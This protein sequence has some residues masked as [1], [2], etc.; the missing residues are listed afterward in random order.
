MRIVSKARHRRLILGTAVFLLSAGAACAE[1]DLITLRANGSAEGVGVSA[2]NAGIAAAQREALD[3]L[4]QS[5]APGGT[6][7]VFEPI[8]RN[9]SKY[10][11]SYDV[12]RCDVEGKRTH[13]EIDAHFLERPLR[14]DVAATMLPRLAS[15]PRIQLLIGEQIGGDKIIAV[16]DQG[17]AETA[18]RAGLK[19]L[20]MESLGSDSLG[21]LYTQAQLIGI[22]NGDVESGGKFARAGLADVVVVGTAVNSSEETSRGS[23]LMKTR[24]V[25][26][27]RVFRGVDGKMVDSLSATAVVNGADT[28]ASG[29]QAVQDACDKLSGEMVVSAVLT[30]LS[31]RPPD[32][33]ILVLD[34]P[35][36]HE[37]LQ[38]VM[39]TIEGM[40]GVSGMEELAYSDALARV[41]FK[42]DGRMALLV[43]ALTS[44]PFEGKD[45]RVR[46]VVA[47]EMET[48]F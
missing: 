5:M 35:G 14:Q 30:V 4:V 46:K 10:V 6:K 44:Q 25:V 20:G 27:L 42:F 19:K 45:L 1:E 24:T 38:A 32:A 3:S 22:V 48:E 40:Q 34:K 21:K 8:L 28:T 9:A 12:L 33:V 41:R 23:N 18:L 11:R 26:T 13:V 37:R 17:L 2:R 15:P 7:D 43:Q 47:R 31:A 16:P 36:S 29:E 39:K